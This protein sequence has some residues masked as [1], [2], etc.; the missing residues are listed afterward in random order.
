MIHVWV[1]TRVQDSADKVTLRASTGRYLAADESGI[2]SADR[3]ARG[4]LEEWTLEP[5]KGGYA[6]RT[7]FGTYVGVDEGALRSGS[8]ARA[9]ERS[10]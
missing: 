4:E 6:L 1:C 5:A 9:C 3:E 10:L 7:R 2:I 8:T